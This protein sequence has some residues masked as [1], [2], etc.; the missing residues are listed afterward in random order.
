M[1]S[2]L[3]VPVAVRTTRRATAPSLLRS[4][5]IVLGFRSTWH[6]NVLCEMGFSGH[7]KG[8][9]GNVISQ[10]IAIMRDAR[11]GREAGHAICPRIRREQG[12][13]H[14]NDGDARGAKLLKRRRG[15]RVRRVELDRFGKAP[16]R[17]SGVLQHLLRLPQTHMARG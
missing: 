2:Y 11:F 6:R 15:F 13:R 9:A 12:R 7:G 5:A 17:A 1:R 3:R 8:S 4:N 10:S 14:G 16:R